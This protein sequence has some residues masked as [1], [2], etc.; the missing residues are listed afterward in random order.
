MR[1]YLFILFL[2]QSIALLF[3]QKITIQWEGA[4]INDFGHVKINLPSFRNNGFSFDQNN[5]FIH[6]KQNIRE[7][8]IKITNLQW[9]N[10]AERELYDLDRNNLPEFETTDVSY[11]NGENGRTA[12]VSV[13]LFKKIDGKILRLSSFEMTE[14]EKGGSMLQKIGSTDN[15]LAS[16]NFYKIKVD[17]SGIFKITKDFLQSIGINAGSVNPK[18]LR[19][20]GNGGLI[21]PEH[22]QNKRYSALQENAIQVTGE[23]DGVWNDGDYALFYAQGPDGYNLYN[24]TNG[25]GFKRTDTRTDRSNNVKNIYEDFSYYF[26]TFDKGPGKRVTTTDAALPANL[27]TRYH[28]YQVINEE[29]RNLLKLGKVWV[30]DQPFTNSKSISIT[31]LSAP[32]PGEQVLYRTQ[33]IGYKAQGN[34]LA[35]NINN[36]NPATQTIST[37]ANTPDFVPMRFTGTLNNAQ[38]TT[39]TFNYEPNISVNP[40]GTFYFDYLEIQY[41]E[42][43]AFNGSQMNFR[44]FSLVSGSGQTYGFSVSNA[45]AVEQIWDVTDIT[46][47]N[48]RVNKASGSSIFN[49]GYITNNPDFNNE[50]VAF[51]AD[52]AY[53]PTFVGK[54]ENQNL[55]ALQ[56]VDYLILTR[57]EMMMQ[58]QR[59][60]NY[61]QTKNN[62][63]TQIVDIHKIYNEYSSGG[64]D[65]TAI[66]DFVTHLNTPAGNLKY[67]FILGDATYDFKHKTPNSYNVVPSYQSE[68]SGNYVTSFVTD[69]YFVMTSPQTTT[70]LGFVLPDLPIG[71][72][73]AANPQEAKTMMDKTLAYYNSLPGQSSPF[74]IWR[75]KLD[76]VV[77][78]DKDG[79][80]PFHTIMNTALEEVFEGTTDK[81]EY[82]VRK[83]YMDAFPA[84]STAAGQRYPQVN[85]AIANDIGNSLYLFYF[86]HGGINGWSQERVLT[87][88]EVQGLNNFSPVYS[89]F[90][91]VST[92]TCEFT[93]WDDHDTYS[94]GEQFIKHKS[95]GAATMITSSRAV[96][97]G[98]G[99]TFSG[100]FTKSVFTL[101]AT[102]DFE[103]LGNAHLT[104]KKNYG[105]S[106]DHLKVN[107]LGDP[108][109]KL[110]RPKKLLFIDNIES[111]VPGQIRALDFVKIT[112]HINHPNGTVN[113]GFNGKVI[114]NI[115][116][117]RVNK[118]T[119]NNDGTLTPILHYTEEGSPI[120]KA[121]GTAVNGQFTVEFYVPNDINYT[122]G[123]GRIIAYADN[124]I[125]DVFQN[126]PYQIGDINPNGINDNEPP[127][128]K[129]Y[130]NNTNFADG[131][132]TDQNPMLLACVTDDT[133]INS[134]GAGIGHDII[135]YLDGQII[136]TTVLNDFYNPG[137]GN[138]C[139]N[140]TLA[141]Y[142][143][144]SV[145]YPFRN[146]APGEHTLTFRVWDINNNSTTETLRFIVKDEASQNLV[147]NRPLN[148]PNPFTDKTY[149]H[150][151]HNCDDILDV[152]VQIFTITGKL[153]KTISQTVM[154]EPFLQGFRTPRHAI[155]W[156]GK[157]DFG[158]AVGKGTYIFKI[159]ARSQ[160]Q[161]KCKGGATAIEKMVLLR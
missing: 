18:N 78:D 17:K 65:L 145:T 27:I 62:F 127:R 21:L 113:T 104:A 144:G 51:R 132:I 5:I 29:K 76:F 88:N 92:I 147:I 138:G 58:A 157:D 35:F 160:N 94:V 59:L 7:K 101:N 75:M 38:G 43:L 47:A 36:Q 97:V 108:A 14:T 6:T 32:L 19:I 98:Y 4:K 3:S 50:F 73:P 134:T 122:V 100:T 99:E 152:N 154:A 54:V 39:F 33:V 131:G 67:V 53:Q 28:E 72:I 130:M 26:I 118:S 69:D 105:G 70:N 57:P 77:D 129:L 10:V 153:V 121:S 64:Q 80:T 1:R 119:L 142:Q 110:S 40:N 135:T 79:G 8:D 9:E 91:F 61:H 156:D 22:N 48:R 55:Q 159:F 146:L 149:I 126:Q 120:V 16:G 15:P 52:A 41:K 111:P 148:W 2:F 23:D 139:L 136:N 11:V 107:Y 114:V 68:E 96:N 63:N 34:S 71:R 12:L 20:Y 117:K 24:T 83:L 31:T 30:D 45:S 93:L 158:D 143:K 85:Q 150:F 116:D 13:G 109:M 128:V 161:E 102:E 42:N 141:E 95:G 155:G 37:T 81:P 124:N 106:S 46:N 82:N 133:G 151:E 25:N 137:D 66:R 87:T 112:G 89:R 140:P 49:F 74:G 86:G 123:T 103:T 90:P 56:N 84:E 115:F 125:E 44:D 60:A